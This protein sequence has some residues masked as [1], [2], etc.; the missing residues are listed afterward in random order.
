LM[1]TAFSRGAVQKRLAELGVDVSALLLKPVTPSTLLDACTSA[2]GLSIPRAPRLARR[3]EQSQAH[4]EQLRGA[5]ILLVEDNIIN[6]EI[7]LTLLRRDG[8]VASVASD[9]QEA[10][11]M[12]KRQPFD[13]VL[14]DCQMPVLDGYAATRAIR[15][16]PRWQDLPVIA[17]TANALV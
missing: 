13:G 14:M 16:E 9:G 1:M 4:R 2:L 15:Q 17:M 11:D 5:R 10:L 12:L 6:Q 3:E 8:I 7:A